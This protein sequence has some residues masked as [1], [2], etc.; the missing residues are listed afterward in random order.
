MGEE[1]EEQ[2]EGGAEHEAGD[3]RK[4]ERGVFATVDDVAGKAAETQR[5]LAAKVEKRAKNDQEDAENEEHAA[6]FAEG[7]HEKDSRRKEVKK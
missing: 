5:E 6:E 2:R 7:I 3:D 1:P 4:I